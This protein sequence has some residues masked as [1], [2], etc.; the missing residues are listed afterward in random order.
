M[1]SVFTV[2]LT[3]KNGLYCELDLPATPYQ[4]LDALEKLWMSPAERTLENRPFF[5]A[6]TGNEMADR[7]ECD[8][9]RN[10]LAGSRPG[11]TG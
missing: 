6:Q 8:Y 9:D 5:P 11:E 4:M 1:R 3:G 10:L 2:E 7:K